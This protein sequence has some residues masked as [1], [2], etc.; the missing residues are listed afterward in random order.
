MFLGGIPR[1]SSFRAGGGDCAPGPE[2][3]G[4]VGAVWHDGAARFLDRRGG[5]PAPDEAEAFGGRS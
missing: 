3:E 2:V 1:A 4:I 5:H